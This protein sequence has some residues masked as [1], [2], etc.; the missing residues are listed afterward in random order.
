MAPDA[1]V[2]LL[3]TAQ[4]GLTNVAKHARARTATLR[5]AYGPDRVTLT[6]SDDGG[7]FQPDAPSDGDSAGLQG[8]AGRLA[9][10]GGTLTVDSSSGHGT[11]LTA[12]VPTR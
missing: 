8:L 10:L 9:A 2:A 11:D 3:R 5:L 6:V 12:E 1:E 4:E 7:G